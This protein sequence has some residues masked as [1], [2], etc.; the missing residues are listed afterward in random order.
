MAKIVIKFPT[1]SRP[2]KF[3]KV[4]EK[5]IN[6]L[7]GK[8]DVRYVVSMDTDDESMN[9]E[10]IRSWFEGLKSKGVDIKYAYG[11]SKTKIEACNADM[12]GETGD[13]LILMSDDMVPCMEGYDD[14]IAMGFAQCFPDYVGA[15]K[16]NDGLRGPEDLLMTLP[17]LGF[18]LFEAMGH[19]YHPD[20]TSLYCDTEMTALFSKMGMLAVSPTCIIRH[21]WLPGD[22]PDADEL[23]QRNENAEMYG[24]DGEVYQARMQND[25]DMKLVKERLDAKGL[26]ST[27]T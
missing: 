13:I 8:H 9:N 24:K 11:N 26:I 6:F 19:I 3:K 25:F 18:P 5:S 1:R 20:Y 7:S 12:E 2:D 17:V 23:H 14:I 4:F 27:Q 16:F 21:E 22:H 15:I 10:D